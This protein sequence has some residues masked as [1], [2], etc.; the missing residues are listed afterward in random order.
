MT[1]SN[2]KQSN[3]GEEKVVPD[4]PYHTDNFSFDPYNLKLFVINLQS[5]FAKKAELLNLIDNY[6]PNIIIGSET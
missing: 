2:K 6:H 3:S 5:I 1:I 4:S